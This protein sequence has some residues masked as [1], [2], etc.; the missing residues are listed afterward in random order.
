MTLEPGHIVLVP[1]PFGNLRSTKQRPALVLSRA[2][3]NAS[4]PDVVVCALT[5]NLAAAGHSVLVSQ[6]DMAQGTLAADSRVK[7]DKLATLDQAI[8]RKTVGKLRPAALQQVF[9]ELMTLLPKDAF[10]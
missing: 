4:S 9:R 10:R 6:R 8:L 5:S 7:V 2:D 1:F 3:Y